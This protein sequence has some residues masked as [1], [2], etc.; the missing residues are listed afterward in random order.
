[1]ILANTAIQCSEKDTLKKFKRQLTNGEK[2]F[3][4]HISDKR[5]CPEDRTSKTQKLRKQASQIFKNKLV[6]QTC[7]PPVMAYKHFKNG[8]HHLS[9]GK[10]K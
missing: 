3:E 8:Y 4:N 5:L 1:M 2:I 6:I 10:Y 9:L 7:M